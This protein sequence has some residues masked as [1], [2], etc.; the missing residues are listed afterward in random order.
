MK[1]TPRNAGKMNRAAAAARTREDGLTE[2]RFAGSPTAWQWLPDEASVSVEK[3]PGGYRVGS[4]S[5]L[6]LDLRIERQSKTITLVRGTLHGLGEATP[7]PVTAPDAMVRDYRAGGVRLAGLHVAA[8]S[9]DAFQRPRWRLGARLAEAVTLDPGVA[10]VR[11]PEGEKR[12]GVH[13]WQWGVPQTARLGRA[14]RCD[15]PPVDVLLYPPRTRRTE[16]IDFAF[17][18]VTAPEP[19]FNPAVRKLA[20]RVGIPG[21]HAGAA[22]KRMLAIAHRPTLFLTC[23]SNP[24]RHDIV[25]WAAAAGFGSILLASTVWTA[26]EGH[27][28]PNLKAWPKGWA[29][30]EA[31]FRYARSRGLAVGLHTHTAGLNDSDPYVTPVPDDRLLS[32]WN[33]HLAKAAGPAATE[34]RLAETPAGFSPRDDYMSFGKVIRIGDEFIR[35][36]GADERTRTLHGCE[37]GAFGTRAAAHGAGAGVRYMFRCFNEFTVDPESTLADEVAGHIARAFHRTGAEMIYF[38]CS[39]AVPDPYPVTIGRFH[40]KV[41]RAIGWPHLHVQASSTAAYGLHMVARAGQQDTAIHKRALLDHVTM[42]LAPQFRAAGITPDLGWYGFVFGSADHDTMTLDDIDCLMARVLG[43]DS[44]VTIMLDQDPG[45]APGFPLFQRVARQMGLWRRAASAGISVSR[46]RALATVGREFRPVPQG[47]GVRIAE[48]LPWR[49]R[50][51]ADEKGVVRVCVP[52]AGPAQPMGL[53]MTMRS[54]AAPRGDTGNLR[55]FAPGDC[56]LRGL[57]GATVAG[58]VPVESGH[59]ILRWRHNGAGVTFARWRL[60]FP[61]P[62]D[63]TGHRPLSLRYRLDGTCAAAAVR[64][65]SGLSGWVLGPEY[66]LPVARGRWLTVENPVVDPDTRFAHT[67][68]DPWFS[69]YIGI[70]LQRVEALDII[71]AGVSGNGSMRLDAIEG[72]REL[73]PPGSWNVSQRAGDRFL[74]GQAIPWDG[75]FEL[76]PDAGGAAAEL[77]ELSGAVR[78]AGRYA[79]GDV[80]VLRHGDNRLEWIGLAPGA[81]ADVRIDR[82]LS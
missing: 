23:S 80:P 55:L 19:D 58:R 31:F 10:C 42:A 27:Y 76:T 11:R 73:R 78:W 7:A 46:R 1:K 12:D 15:S 67:F 65:I 17:A 34:L 9:A 82:L 37:R 66:G 25:D 81:W 45:M 24:V 41:W 3:A 47:R 63:L 57:D 40:E 60:I 56:A 51:R 2:L 20:A 29:S 75:T 59:A 50:C 32:V 14:A 69:T 38:D 52:N 4:A 68:P 33:G 21:A 5:G 71:L 26:A 35:Y 62:L 77:M 61:E 22:R 49:Q 74:L 79:A 30:L 16:G 18:L 6:A 70:P 28:Q 36:G 72:L 13:H 44:G 43:S 54:P 8:A 48:T 64:L 39:E 53:R